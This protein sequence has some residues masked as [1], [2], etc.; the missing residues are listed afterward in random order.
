MKAM[1]YKTGKSAM[2]SGVAISEIWILKPICTEKIF[3]QFQPANW[4]S[5]TSTVGQLVMKFS[6]KQ[7]AILFCKEH[8]IS[9]KEIP[10]YDKSLKQKSYTQT[11]TQQ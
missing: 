2:Q 4:S 1:L 7:K 8:N 5:S 6:S 3:F 10:Y 11:I 9:Y